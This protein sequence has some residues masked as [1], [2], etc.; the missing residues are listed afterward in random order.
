MIYYF[1]VEKQFLRLTPLMIM[2]TVSNMR[3][4]PEI[5]KITRQRQTILDVVLSMSSHPSA[6]EIYE[7]VRKKMPHIS[8]GTVYRNLE[9][10]SK[11][12]LIRK[13]EI[14]GHQKHF[15]FNLNEH[16]HTH[17]KICGKVV[18]VP[19]DVKIK[20]PKD[21]EKMTG[22]SDV[23]CCIEFMGICPDCRKIKK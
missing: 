6:D 12:G 21:I 23:E 18:D 11:A 15:D 20:V 19:T 4:K 3:S 22:F 7:Q 9:L 16:A 14:A 13:I 17:C 5:K 8:L 2:I 1:F 10:L